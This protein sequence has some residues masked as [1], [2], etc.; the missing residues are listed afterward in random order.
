MRK[1]IADRLRRSSLSGFTLVEILVVMGIVAIM[2]ALTAVA[3][4]N[5]YTSSALK[6]ARNETYQALADARNRTLASH[7]ASTFGVLV[8]TS[9]VTRFTGTSYMVGAPD[10]IVYEYEGGVT[11]T[12]TLV[13]GGTSVIFTRLTGEP[14]V[15]GTFLFMT[16]DGSATRTVTVHPSG[17]I[18]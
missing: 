18:E 17:L 15:T 4:Q 10:N 13:V 7:G 8:G 6:I 1:Q 3:F 9:S 2:A 14:S 12:G 16:S 5:F 11:A